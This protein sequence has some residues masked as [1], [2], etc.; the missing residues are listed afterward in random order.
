MVAQFKKATPRVSEIPQHFARSVPL[1]L[2]YTLKHKDTGHYLEIVTMVDEHCNHDLNSITFQSLPKQRMLSVEERQIVE[3]SLKLKAN[4]LK[5]QESLLKMGKK[6]TLKDIHNVQTK[7]NKTKTNDLASIFELLKRDKGAIVEVAE[8]NDV[9][10]G[11]FFQDRIMQQNLKRFPEVMFVDATYKLN[12]YGMP[13]F[14]TLV[15]DG[16]GESQILSLWLV[17]SESYKCVKTMC[18]YMKFHN[19]NLEDLEVIV[20][21]KDMADRH[22]FYDSFP[23]VSIHICIFHALRIFKREITVDKRNI[24]S[25]EIKIVLDILQKMVYSKTEDIYNDLHSK[26]IELD[27]PLVSLYF[28]IKWHHIRKEWAIYW[29]NESPHLLNLT[30]N[31]LESLNQKIK[32]VVNKYSP[33]NDLFSDLSTVVGSQAYERQFRNIMSV[34][35]QQIVIRIIYP[36]HAYSTL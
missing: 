25:S 15:V 6:M 32:R 5:I 33:L 9:L 21:D 17:Q 4:K 2:H 10:L 20:A 1:N 18:V 24:T 13:L 19:N 22:A 35:R 27:M 14:I 31:R 23:G 29:R 8:E 28:N 12:N 34:E 36:E 7:I 30:N 26:L 11:I 3:N 16:N